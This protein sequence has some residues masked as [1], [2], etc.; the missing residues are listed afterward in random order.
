MRDPSFIGIEEFYFLVCDF[1][2][3]PDGTVNR[4]GA[5][6]LACRNP[7]TFTHI[8]SEGMSGRIG[9]NLMA[10]AIDGPGRRVYLEATDEHRDA[11]RACKPDWKPETEL[12]ESALGFRV[13]KY[14]IT[15]HSDLFHT[16]ANDNAVI[17]VG[18]NWRG[19]RGNRQRC[20][21]RCRVCKFSSCIPRF[22]L[23]PGC[24]NQQH[25][26]SLAGAKDRH[27]KRNARVRPADSLNVLGVLG[28][29]HIWH[30]CW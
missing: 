21:R 9:Y 16:P 30:I 11:V 8:R 25:P 19:S 3:P 4:S 17:T 7:V 13:Q 29:K 10:M 28:G 24:P 14:G 15:R 26:C 27:L 20:K 1:G 2:E 12:P 5:V 18:I 22:K 23:K 6:C